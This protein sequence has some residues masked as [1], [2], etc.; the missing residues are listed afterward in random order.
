MH[1][2]DDPPGLLERLDIYTV[3]DLASLTIIGA[4]YHV[5]AGVKIV[6][7]MCKIWGGGTVVHT[8]VGGG[9]LRSPDALT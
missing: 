2:C 4:V 3:S 9:L 1:F 7:R 6:M 8:E 5:E